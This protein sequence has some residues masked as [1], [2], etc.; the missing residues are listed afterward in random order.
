M[1]QI[2]DQVRA[3]IGRVLIDKDMRETERVWLQS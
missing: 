3:A 2:T 1:M